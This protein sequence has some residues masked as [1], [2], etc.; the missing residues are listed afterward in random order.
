MKTKK[1]TVQPYGNIAVDSGQLLIIDPSYLEM[2]MKQYSYDDICSIE[3]NMQFPK[4]H[5][6]IALKLGGF[7]G[8]GMFDVD[9]VTFYNKYSPPYSQFILNLY[10]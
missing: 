1:P 6:G 7:G 2:F 5:D 9:S 10:E 8:D 3:G 4:G